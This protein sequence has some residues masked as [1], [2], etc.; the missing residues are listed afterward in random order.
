MKTDISSKFVMFVQNISWQSF[1]SGFLVSKLKQNFIIS[2]ERSILTGVS[3]SFIEFL[4][5][6]QGT[7]IEHYVNQCIQCLHLIWFLNIL[8]LLNWS[9]CSKLQ[10]MATYAAR[11]IVCSNIELKYRFIPVTYIYTFRCHL[12]FYFYLKQTYRGLLTEGTL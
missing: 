8:P 11:L 9:E 10:Q 6:Y 12:L 4:E 7:N 3:L 2:L 1:V 5:R